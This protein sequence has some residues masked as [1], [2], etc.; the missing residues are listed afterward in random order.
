M[1]T[2]SATITLS[3]NP[4]QSR[5]RGGLNLGPAVHLTADVADSTGEE[6]STRNCVCMGPGFQAGNVILRSVGPTTP[7][8]IQPDV[9][10]PEI[11][12]AFHQLACLSDIASMNPPR[13]TQRP[14]WLFGIG[15]RNGAGGL[16]IGGNVRAVPVNPRLAD[17]RPG[18]ST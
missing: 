1:S 14:H 7:D 12:D 16:G 18:V 4:L 2:L 9:V 5:D 17:G 15:I 11:A 13:I 8:S 3:A 10:H 6:S